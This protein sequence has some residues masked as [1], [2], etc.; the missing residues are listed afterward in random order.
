MVIFNELRICEDGS[1]LI[2]DCEIENVDVYAN[3]YIKNIYIDYYKNA[4]AVNMPTSSAYTIYDNTDDDTT[5][6]GKRVV[7][8]AGQLSEAGFGISSFSDGLFY[9][10]VDC[11]GVPDSAVNFMPCGYDV[12]REIG[13]VLDWVSFYKKG[14]EYV[15]SMLEGCGNP[16]MPSTAFE[17]F[18]ITWNGLKLAIDTCDWDAV[19]DL[20]D[21]VIF[22]S[23]VSGSA[24]AGAGAVVYGGCGCR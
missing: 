8:D 5:I 3:M 21:R 9:V 16:C 4:S 11:G 23:T 10:I 17:H 7:F 2:V 18:I 1:A 24:E 14:M 6:K 20:W 13:V 19:K 12:P 22:S 15:T